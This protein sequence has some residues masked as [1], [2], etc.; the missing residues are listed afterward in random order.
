M[1]ATPESRN[2]RI[3]VGLDGSDESLAALRRGYIVATA[4]NTELV[5][6]TVWHFPAGYGSLATDWSPEADANEVQE[7]AVA[8]VFGSDAPSWFRTEVLEGSPAEVLIRESQ[9]AQMLIV[10]S[11]GHG[12]FSGLL[13]GSVSSACAEHARCPVLVMR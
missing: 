10:G 13:L 9:D 3:V 12:G 7:T 2:G 5:A 11:R 1:N 4:L 8:A 6:V